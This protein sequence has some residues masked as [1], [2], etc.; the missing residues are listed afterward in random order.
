[1]LSTASI[2]QG[3]RALLL[4]LPGLSMLAV[5]VPAGI[6]A[7]RFG[8]R[9]MTLGA[10]ALMAGACVAQSAPSLTL[11]LAG[12]IAFG[13]A[14]GVIWT[15][16]MAW[17]SEIDPGTKG[18]R[19]GPAITYSSV[20]VMAGPAVGGILAQE[21]G[22][23][24][25]FLLTAMLAALATGAVSA[26]AGAECR[27]APERSEPQAGPT[28]LRALADSVR[29]PGVG[30]AAGALIVA[31]AVS[32]ASQLL[33]TIGLHGD[34]ISTGSIGLAFSASAVCY[35]LV[36]AWVVRLGPRA[37]SLRFSA[38]A[39]LALALSMAPALA[40]GAPQLLVLAL[41]LIAPPR[42]A[43]G[44]VAYSLAATSGG[45]RSDRA[46]H[47][48]DGF[49]FGML[50]GAWAAAMVLAPIV[51]GALYQDAGPTAAYLAVIAPSC[52]VGVWLVARSRPASGA[53]ALGL[54]SGRLGSG[55]VRDLQTPELVDRDVALD[56]MAGLGVGKR[57]LRR[58]ADISK[59]AGAAGVKN[60]AARRVGCARDLSL[61]ANSLFRGVLERRHRGQQRL[62]VRMV[63]PAE[64][65]LGRADLHDPAEVKHGDS[66]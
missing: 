21:A 34:G 5:S 41:L 4:A 53:R 59:V 28:S 15:A 1:M 25:P 50:N 2:A 46:D 55:A 58:L 64:H 65:G 17:L 52:A 9:R 6:A 7:D 43:I 42:A 29:R 19:L 22:V 49:V 12:R 44:T 63:R 31:G 23:A 45:E 54:R 11:L 3:S 8:A 14:F 24:A 27:Q 32:G 56:R 18:A 66:V 37:R 13:I 26:G 48:A 10:G 30:A 51:A 33:I 57:R 60:A 61:E 40:G 16:G 36:S 39:T 62:R 20:G 38:L 47:R 35:L